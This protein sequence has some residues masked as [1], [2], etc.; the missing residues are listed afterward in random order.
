[1][2]VNMIYW[3][4][5]NFKILLIYFT[6]KCT[7]KNLAKPL[8]LE[9]SYAQPPD[10]PSLRLQVGSKTSEINYLAALLL[11]S[12]LVCLKDKNKLSFGKVVPKELKVFLKRLKLPNQCTT[13]YNELANSNNSQDLRVPLNPF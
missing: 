6:C 13:E 8:R 3:A 11:L 12:R 5:N 10:K 2:L 1:M 7:F 4:I 9:D